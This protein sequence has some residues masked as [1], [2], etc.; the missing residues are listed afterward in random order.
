MEVKVGRTY[1]L[2]EKIGGGAFGEVFRGIN[3]KTQMGNILF[4]N[5]MLLW[6]NI[7]IF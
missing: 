3:E 5:I 4:V 6:K 2:I 7:Y 1:K